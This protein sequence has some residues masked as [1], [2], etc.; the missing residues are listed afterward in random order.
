MCFH[1]DAKSRQVDNEDPSHTYGRILMDTRKCQLLLTKKR[2]LYMF[3]KSLYFRD[4]FE[5]DAWSGAMQGIIWTTEV[6][7]NDGQGG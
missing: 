2:T 6:G 1:G 7:M 4:G 5:N 3:L